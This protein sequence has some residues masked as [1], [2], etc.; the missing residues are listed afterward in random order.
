MFGGKLGILIRYLNGSSLFRIAISRR[1][2]LSELRKPSQGRFHTFIVR[3]SLAC[4]DL[5]SDSDEIPLYFWKSMD[6]VI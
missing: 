6:H 1:S 2:L 3:V 4:R 5:H